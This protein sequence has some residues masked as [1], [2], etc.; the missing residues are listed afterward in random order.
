M[1]RSRTGSLGRRLSYWLALQ[2]LVGLVVVCAVVYGATQLAFQ[3]RQAEALAQKRTQLQHLVVE[4][5]RDG[6]MQALKHKLDD[7]LIGHEDLSLRLEQAAGTLFYRSP[8]SPPTHS[9]AR[10]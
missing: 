2:S 4:A 9:P 1:S 6:D 8:A 7:F 10:C 3:D 5:T